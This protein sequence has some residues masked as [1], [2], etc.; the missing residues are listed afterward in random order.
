MERIRRRRAR[1]RAS[2]ISERERERR[3]QQRAFSINEF[4]QVYGI[5][6]SK[7]YNELHSGRLRGRKIGKRTVIAEVDAEDWLLR[8]PPVSEALT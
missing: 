2:R 3:A 4:S 6:R 8:L 7:I 1:R 5:G